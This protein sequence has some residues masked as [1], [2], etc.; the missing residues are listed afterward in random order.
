MA[1]RTEK[2]N[3]QVQF[4][5]TSKECIQM[6]K[7]LSKEGLKASG[8]IITR[9]LKTKIPVRTGGLKKSIVAWAKIDYK[10]GIPYMEVG[11]RSRA[12]M[13]KRGVKYFVNPWWF[14][15]GNKPHEIMTKDMK[16]RGKSSYQLHDHQR[17]YGVIVK[18]PGMTNKNF[19]RNT[20]MENIEE[21]Q[22]AQEE[23]FKSLTEMM[24]Q[25]GA[26]ID[27][28]EDEEIE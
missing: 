5:D 22:K 18:H 21:I 4:V 17:S 27:L 23:A 16:K 8:K 10:T 19:L 13:K 25:E 7:K 1:D 6:M 2:L 3:Q 28:G 24:I 15:F 20:V 26:K 14:E 12:Q 11:Y 9:T